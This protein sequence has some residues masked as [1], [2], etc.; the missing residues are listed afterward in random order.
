MQDLEALSFPVLADEGK[1]NRNKNLWCNE[2]QYSL[3]DFLPYTNSSNLMR[4]NLKKRII[5]LV[6]FFCDQVIEV[7]FNLILDEYSKF[8]PHI[9][10]SLC[11]IRAY[12]IYLTSQENRRMAKKV[13]L[14]NFLHKARK[15]RMKS[16]EMIFKIESGHD[17]EE[18]SLKLSEFL[19]ENNLNFFL[20]EELC[21]LTK[22]LILTKYKKVEDYGEFINYD[23]F[24][25]DTRLS[26]YILR[27]VVH[28]FQVEISL[29]SC[30]FIEKISMGFS[31][32]D[33]IIESLMHLKKKDDDSRHVLPCHLVMEII[34]NHAQLNGEVLFNVKI[35]RKNNGE[36]HDN[37][38]IH[39]EAGATGFKRISN[40][41]NE[42]KRLCIF[43]QGI[44]EL[45]CID[46]E[47]KEVFI[48]R[49]E[50]TGMKHIISC[51]MAKHYQYPGKKLE[52]IE[53]SFDDFLLTH[54]DCGFISN[55]RK[56]FVYKKSCFPLIGCFDEQLTH[57]R[58]KH[59][60]CGPLTVD[61]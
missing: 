56:E 48:S 9:G 15:V 33:E 52:K 21:V 47:P 20:S 11:Q 10:E 14:K 32:Y 39:Y 34:M 19:S 18:I 54:N 17:K 53:K 30:R 46:I 38:H 2:K 23:Q 16:L 58:I 35:E 4:K 36:I 3:I 37:I 57:Y 55:Y 43:I 13:A 8:D 50:K 61:N 40:F 5:G 25:E 41:N 51:S 12:M 42:H 31:N 7:I 22:F 27:K 1:C 49:I 60:F 28:S 29:M 59:I 26:K 44:M 45:N 6:C 24:I